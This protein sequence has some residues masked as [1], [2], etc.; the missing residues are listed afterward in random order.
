MKK[1]LIAKTIV[2]L[3]VATLSLSSI[4]AT[5]S[6]QVQADINAF[7]GYF[8]KTY[9][10]IKDFT[11]GPYTFSEDRRSQFEAVME[12]PPFED[13]VDKGEEAWEAPFKNG[14]TYSSC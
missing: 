6:K 10:E 14:K 2:G 12:M 11:K 5:Q 4:A 3:S 8:A 9:P 1:T 7:Q 13:H